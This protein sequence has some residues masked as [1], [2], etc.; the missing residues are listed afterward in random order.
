MNGCKKV[1]EHVLGMY[2]ELNLSDWAG[3]RTEIR[4][5]LRDYLWREIKR[6]PMILPMLL[7]VKQP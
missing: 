5:E 2:R 6:S 3:L 7:D 1:V 4:D